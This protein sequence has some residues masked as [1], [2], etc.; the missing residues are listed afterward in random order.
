MVRVPGP[1]RFEL[2]L[3]D[4]AVNRYLLQAVIIAAGLSGLTKKADPGP[5]H[6]IDMYSEGHLVKDAPRLPLNLLDAL[7]AYERDDI[8]KD[9]LGQ[10]FSAA[11]LKLKHAE[12]DFFSVRN[13][14]LG[15]TR[16][17]WTSSSIVLV[18][19]AGMPWLPPTTMASILMT[20]LLM[21]AAVVEKALAGP[22]AFRSGRPHNA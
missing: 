18:A 21:L 5:H 19:C 6:D 12:W 20:S 10:D 11:Y 13:S 8:I 9:A 4:G 1:G 22:M 16:Q 3:A 2:R 17:R 14:R 7:R 15:S